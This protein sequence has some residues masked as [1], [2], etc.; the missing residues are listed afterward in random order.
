MVSE[1]RWLKGT[2]LVVVGIVTVGLI[3]AGTQTGRSQVQTPPGTAPFD[4]T[5]RW[6]TAKGETV[7]I[8]HDPT[9]QVT[10]R[11][12][13]VIPCWD[14]TRDEYFSA[15]LI[16]TG[17]GDAASYKLEGDKYMACTNTK[18]MIDDC[19]VQKVFQT[20]FKADVSPDANTISG[21]SFRPGYAFEVVNDRY[22][23][24][25]RSA[26]YDGWQDFVLTRETEPTPTPTPTPTPNTPYPTPTPQQSTFC[27]GVPQKNAD[28][29]REIDRMIDKLDKEIAAAEEMARSFER[30]ARGGD[31]AAARSARFY[32]TKAS[33]LG[34][35]KDYWV[36]IKLA[37]C[38]PHEII[39]LLRSVL[40]GRVELCPRLCDL[41]AQWIG[42]MTP[43][44]Q[45]HL[46][47]NEFLSLCKRYCSS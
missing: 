18:K 11:F 34:K 20:K 3:W 44:P 35:L 14:Q 5:G 7:V 9:G 13:P 29:D 17:S 4:L 41:A 23:N 37:P 15:P 32:R 33:D 30:K 36:K 42:T 46:Q 26:E 12:S 25:R 16:R 27:D 8:R 19:R 1:F 10:A 21:S 6:K 28:D 47:R 2:F 38:I 24:C 39:E 31:R 22:V 40:D 45:G 43:G